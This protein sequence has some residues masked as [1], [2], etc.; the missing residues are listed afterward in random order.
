M[1]IETDE[2]NC[3]VIGDLSELDGQKIASY[4]KKLRLSQR[5]FSNTFQIPLG[6]LR[7]WEQ[8]Q[9]TPSQIRKELFLHNFK[10]LEEGSFEKGRITF[11]TLRP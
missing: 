8:S 9:N 4:R 11:G 1:K 3:M 7:R 6:T 2:D 10:K 5:E